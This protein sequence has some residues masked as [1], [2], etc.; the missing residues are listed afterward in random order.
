MQ[1]VNLLNFVLKI[2][3]QPLFRSARHQ[4]EKRQGSGSVRTSTNEDWWL[5]VKFWGLLPLVPVGCGRLHPGLL[6]GQ[7]L[8]RGH[9][10]RQVPRRGAQQQY[11]AGR[12]EAP[13]H[14]AAREYRGG[15]GHI[16]ARS[17]RLFLHISLPD[18]VSYWF[19]VSGS[20]LI[21]I[22][23]NKEEIVTQVGIRKI[24]TEIFSALTLS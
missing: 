12:Q 22:W 13:W 3:L 21:N 5:Q 8:V 6:C 14:C 19:P 1:N 20:L 16:S 24:I 17:E 10:R 4:Y 9:L 7:V 23:I 18:P 11:C 15:G 2:F